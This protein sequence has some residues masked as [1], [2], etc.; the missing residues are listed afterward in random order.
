MIDVALWLVESATR[1]RGVPSLAVAMTIGVLTGCLFTFAA[2][3]WCVAGFAA[4]AASASARYRSYIECVTI[5]QLDI[6][7]CRDIASL[8]RG[9][10]Q[11]IY[12][13]IACTLGLLNVTCD[14]LLSF[15]QFFPCLSF[16]CSCVCFSVAWMAQDAATEH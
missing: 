14:A 15:V 4:A 12:L 8:A 16:F 13:I 10:G 2:A 1:L 9:L 7:V 6:R 3:H 5:V 11:G